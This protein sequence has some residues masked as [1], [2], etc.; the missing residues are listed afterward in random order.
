MPP[1]RDGIETINRLWTVDP[2]LQVVICTAYSDFAWDDIVSQL[3]KTDNLVILKKPFDVIEVLQLAHAIT[4][5]WEMTRQAR[6]RMNDLNRMVQ[7]STKGLE[8]A[9]VFLKQEIM[10][11]ARVENALRL[12]EE[13]FSKAFQ[14]SPIPIKIINTTEMRLV[15]V[16]Q[17]YLAITGLDAGDLIGQ[18]MDKLPIFCDQEKREQLQQFLQ[19][20]QPILDMEMPI[21]SAS[22]EPLTTLLSAEHFTL[23][24]TPRALIT[25][26]NITE[27][28][29]LE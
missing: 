17:S 2:D 8:E 11:R 23:S 16:N 19:A 18:P 25:L 3:G 12:S 21:K 4:K 14:T 26:Q 20:R 5:K 28:L 6:F 13:R 15:N 1:G 10:K 27:R 29:N 24:E 7:E 22:G 9:N